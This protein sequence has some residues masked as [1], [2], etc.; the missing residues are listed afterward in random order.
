M[1]RHL[2]A[3]AVAATLLAVLAPPAQASTYSPSGSADLSYTVMR[4]D[5]GRK[6]TT[7]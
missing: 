3:T 1:K 7:D 6:W 2:L 4:F 5:Q